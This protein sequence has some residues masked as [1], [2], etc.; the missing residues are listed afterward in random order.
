M[1]CN[2][3]LGGLPGGC[4][5]LPYSRDRLLARGTARAGLP[6]STLRGA[7]TWQSFDAAA[8]HGRHL[9]LNGAREA[10]LQCGVEK[11]NG[12]LS[13]TQGTGLR[14]DRAGAN[15]LMFSLTGIFPPKRLNSIIQLTL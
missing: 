8:P 6:T 2:S 13:D 15:E 7:D 9:T 14:A 1:R 12:C 11:T 10:W 5:T 3:L 4:A